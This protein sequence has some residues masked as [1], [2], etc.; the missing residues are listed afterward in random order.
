MFSTDGGGGVRANLKGPSHQIRVAHQCYGSIP[1]AT[2]T[3]N[4]FLII[5]FL[6][7]PLKF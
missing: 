4:K 5:P 2:L 6:N 3:F 7:A 1:L